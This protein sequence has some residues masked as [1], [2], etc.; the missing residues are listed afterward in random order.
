MKLAVRNEN[1]IR[2]LSSKR[3]RFSAFKKHHFISHAKSQKTNTN[4]NVIKNNKHI[5]NSSHPLQ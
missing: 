2:K 5:K 4:K 1:R 3:N